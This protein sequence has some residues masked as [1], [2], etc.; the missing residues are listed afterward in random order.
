MERLDFA[1][2]AVIYLEL[3]CAVVGTICYSKYKH[4]T[5]RL[6]LGYLW[7]VFVI[8]IS[9]KYVDVIY[10]NNIVI[11]NLFGIVEFGIFTYIFYKELKAT[12]F[13]KVI[14]LSIASFLIA[15][16]INF[17]VAEYSVH[18]FLNYA[19]GCS[20]LLISL[21]CC[22][23]FYYMAQTDKILHLYRMLFTWV[24]I[25]LLV[26]HLCNL[27][28]TVLTNEL[29]SINVNLFGILAICGM[30]NYTCI[31]IGF[32]WTNRQYNTSLY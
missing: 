10:N 25:G 4:S 16:L 19:F 12:F 31:I 32:L 1:L 15:L 8:E 20:S 26:Y 9:A 13:R 24:C 27:P 29:K 6:I 11:Y 23:Y 3:I 7:L 17:A 18:V 2:D 30:F 14:F 5:L 28:I 21:Y 22:F